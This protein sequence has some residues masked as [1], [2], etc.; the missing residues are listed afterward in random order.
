M[1]RNPY[2]DPMHLIQIDMLRRWRD[3]GREDREA[4]AAL[5][6]SVSGISEALQGA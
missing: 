4:F 2:I 5:Q 1:L 3:S 6:A